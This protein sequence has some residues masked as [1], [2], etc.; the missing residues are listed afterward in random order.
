MLY[1][2]DLSGGVSSCTRWA[3]KL[4]RPSDSSQSEISLKWFSKLL[5]Y[6]TSLCIF[7]STSSPFLNQLGFFFF[8]HAHE[9]HRGIINVLSERSLFWRRNE[10]TFIEHQLHARFEA[11]ISI[12]SF[13]YQQC[14]NVE[15]N[16]YSLWTKEVERQLRRQ[17]WEQ[18]NQGFQ[19][20]TRPSGSKPNPF[21][22]HF[23]MLPP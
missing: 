14:C 21:F 9:G 19:I 4:S 7:D 12:I 17:S 6:L 1:S 23:S 2:F 15:I 13:Y 3:G 18:V 22:F 20:Q 8:F 16:M 10:G 5:S 11:Y